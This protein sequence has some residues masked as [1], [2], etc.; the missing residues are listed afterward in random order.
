MYGCFLWIDFWGLNIVY[1][2]YCCGGMFV[3]CFDFGG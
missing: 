2:N 1:G 3:G